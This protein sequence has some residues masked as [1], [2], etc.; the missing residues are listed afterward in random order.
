MMEKIEVTAQFKPDGSL[1]PI[2]FIRDS[3]PIRV[4]DVGRQWETE[5]GKHILVMDYQNH[6]H[7]LFFQGKDLTWYLVQ[8]IKPPLIPS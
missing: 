8:D 5:D 4:L 7:H 1:V 2:E 3:E 6:V